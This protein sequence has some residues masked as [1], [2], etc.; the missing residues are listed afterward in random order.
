M[1]AR[2]SAQPSMHSLSIE[3]LVDLKVKIV[4][5][6]VENISGMQV[7]PSA[8]FSA[9]KE[10]LGTLDRFSFWL[11]AQK[12]F[13]VARA[14]SSWEYFSHQRNCIP[15]CLGW[16]KKILSVHGNFEQCVIVTTGHCSTRESYIQCMPMHLHR[17]DIATWAN[18]LHIWCS[19]SMLPC[20]LFSLKE[21]QVMH[22][23]ET[24]NPFN[25]V[26]Y[27]CTLYPMRNNHWPMHDSRGNI[28]SALCCW[29][30]IF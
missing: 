8:L 6:C 16:L 20:H 9:G 15:S 5:A 12:L 2:C 17:S 14:S 13:F 1:P 26:P 22:G 3:I 23:F 30:F 21:Y 29:F 27:T 7:F 4:S 19:D 24:F 10:F 25:Q 11:D 28:K 18:S